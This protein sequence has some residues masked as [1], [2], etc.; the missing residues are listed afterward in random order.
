MNIGMIH[1]LCHYRGLYR[2]EHNI[3]DKR[4]GSVGCV[5]VCIVI[6]WSAE[7]YP[8]WPGNIS[9][10]D[11]GKTEILYV[12][13]SS[14]DLDRTTVRF[15]DQTIGDSDV[16]RFT[17]AETKDRPPCAEAAISDRHKF[18]AA[19]QSTGIILALYVTI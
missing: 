16:L 12:G 1:R 11:I 17:S 4:L 8:Y 7:T 5:V 19:K 2:V 6:R 18:V 14:A 10:D 9:H 13:P 15:I 3:A